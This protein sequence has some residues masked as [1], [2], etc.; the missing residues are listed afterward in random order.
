MFVIGGK[1]PER[2]EQLSISVGVEAHSGLSEKS[3]LLVLKVK[4]KTFGFEIASQALPGHLST[5]VAMMNWQVES[6]QTI[7]IGL[8]AAP[9]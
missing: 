5:P 8:V 2:L 7:G 6:E 3:F 4:R 1:V 9:K